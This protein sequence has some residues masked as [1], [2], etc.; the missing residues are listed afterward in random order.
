MFFID[1]NKFPFESYLFK[2]AKIIFDCVNDSKN[3]VVKTLRTEHL[4]TFT[5]PWH[6]GDA[7]QEGIWGLVDKRS[8]CLTGENFDQIKVSHSSYCD[9]VSKVRESEIWNP[10]IFSLGIGNP[11]FGVRNTGPKFRIPLSIGIQNP[12]STD[13]GSGWSITWDPKSV[14]CIPESKTVLNSLTWGELSLITVV[15]S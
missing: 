12:S 13:K 1:T 6:V 14:T 2:S 8:R 4:W 10:G 15:A 5:V 3:S 11:C 7:G 9:V